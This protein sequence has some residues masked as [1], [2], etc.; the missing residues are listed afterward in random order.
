MYNVVP[1]HTYTLCSAYCMPVKL[2]GNSMGDLLLFNVVPICIKIISLNGS[3]YV[4]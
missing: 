4:N 3:K 2:V 1:V